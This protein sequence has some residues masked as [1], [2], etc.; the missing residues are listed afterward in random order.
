MKKSLALFPALFFFTLVP[1]FSGP[2]DKPVQP[3][4]DSAAEDK[5]PPS[6]DMKGQALVDM[7]DL[8]KKMV[9]LAQAIPA[10]KYTWRPAPDVRSISEVFL[11]VTAANHN[12]LSMMTGVTADPAFKVNGFE[13]STT[14]K[15]QI[16]DQLDKSFSYAEAAIQAMANADFAR[17]EKKL[18][19]DANSGD[20]I[21]LLV[22]H[23]H[24]HFGQSIAYARVNGVVPPWT[25]E[26]QKKAAEAKKDAA[27]KHD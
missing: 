5:T 24:E 3:V 13:A 23:A 11:H 20:V 17:P 15:A 8:H 19:P 1:A 16:V 6:Y 21:Y 4:A 27:P 7:Q 10:E 14:D 12:I 22:T 26:A 25:L 18:G 9:A 2:R